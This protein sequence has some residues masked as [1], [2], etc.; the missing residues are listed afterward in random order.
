MGQE[1]FSRPAFQPVFFSLSEVG[2]MVATVEGEPAGKGESKLPRLGMVPQGRAL[3]RPSTH[4]PGI[5]WHSPS[6]K[7]NLCLRSLEF[8]LRKENTEL[9]VENGEMG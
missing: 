3:R 9:S 6:D 8:C 4:S 2:Q 5:S 1:A 7:L